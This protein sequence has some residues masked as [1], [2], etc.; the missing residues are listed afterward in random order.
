VLN[1][2]QELRQAELNVVSSRR[3][4]YVAAANVL[5]TMG[6]LEARDLIPSVP[7]YDAA[8]N[9]R[10]LRMTWGWVPW[11]EPISILD[12]AA[13]PWPSSPP[14]VKAEEKPIG[15]GLQPAPAVATQ[16]APR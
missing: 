2:E 5:A 3:D 12:R 11:E 9:F 4:E 1:A 16:P 7:Q 8:R 10:K 6:R 14:A 13:T 15:P